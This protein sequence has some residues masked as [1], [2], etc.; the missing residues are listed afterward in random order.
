MINL[1]NNSY[2][3]IIIPTNRTAIRIPGKEMTGQYNFIKR[4]V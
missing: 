4:T 2:P 1:M 3:V